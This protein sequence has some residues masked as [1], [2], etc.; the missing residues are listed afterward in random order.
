MWFLIW[1]GM[2]LRCLSFTTA[3]G[4][5]VH[6]MRSTTLPHL[7]LFSSTHRSCSPFLT[8]LQTAVLLQI[9]STFSGD[10]FSSLSENLLVERSIKTAAMIPFVTFCAV[11]SAGD[12]VPE[13]A[14]EIAGSTVQFWWYGWRLV[15]T[16][17]AQSHK[18]CASWN[19]LCCYF[20]G[21]ISR[22]WF[23][24]VK[25]QKDLEWRDFSFARERFIMNWPN[26]EE[27][28]KC[29]TVLLYLVLNRWAGGG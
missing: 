24:T 16:W 28:D 21:P 2:S 3:T 15:K 9:T 17:I 20:Q 19:L 11:C 5:W 18:N 13:E 25:L 14:A 29:Q 4:W 22:G 7:A 12:N 23:Q 10:K 1:Q 26:S 8:R 27:K 6:S